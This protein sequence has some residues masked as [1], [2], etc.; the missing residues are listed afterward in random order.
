MSAVA[1][2]KRARSEQDGAD[3]DDRLRR[4]EASVVQ[5][6]V[7]CGTSATLLR[8][9]MI[10]A[11]GLDFGLCVSASVCGGVRIITIGESGCSDFFLSGIN[12]RSKIERLD[13]RLPDTERHDIKSILCF[14]RMGRSGIRRHA[15]KREG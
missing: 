15:L 10:S 2:R 7:P 1:P 8:V 14:G 13:A 4:G 12:E 6:C 3:R 11:R 9:S 5:K